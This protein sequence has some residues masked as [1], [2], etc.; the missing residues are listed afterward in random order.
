MLVG[1]VLKIR[2]GHLLKYRK[3]GDLTQAA[4]AQLCEVPQNQWNSIECMRFSESSWSSIKQIANCLNV[5]TEEVCPPELRGK[6]LRLQAIAFRECEAYRLERYRES[7]NLCLPDPAAEV[8]N[9][10]LSKAREEAVDSIL[11]TLT[12]REREILK[13]RYG[14]GDG[15]EHTLEEVGRVVKLT[16]ERV[17]QVAIRAIHKLQ[18][19]VR[20]DKLARFSGQGVIDK[21]ED[22]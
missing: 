4:A 10:D 16:R 22:R 5:P 6:K 18:H 17:R 2:N 15:R 12:S 8:E 7:K 11:K 1:L 14:L 21:A 13:M 9:L 20:A 3:D 19:P